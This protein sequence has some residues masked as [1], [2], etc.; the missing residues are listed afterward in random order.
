MSEIIIIITWIFYEK[1]KKKQK[2]MGKP[3]KTHDKFTLYNR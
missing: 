2:N 3:Y 1:K